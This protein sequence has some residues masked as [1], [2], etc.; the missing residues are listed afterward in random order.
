MNAHT[1]GPWH[2]GDGTRIIGANSQRVSVC[3]DNHATPGLA[4]A[5]LIAAAPDLLAALK[6]IADTTCNHGPNEVCCRDLAR[7]AIASARGEL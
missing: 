4:N 5:R 7:S 2:I 1:P 6:A 3:D